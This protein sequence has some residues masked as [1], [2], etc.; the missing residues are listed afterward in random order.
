VI[1]LYKIVLFL[2]LSSVITFIFIL[3]GNY[4]TKQVADCIQRSVDEA[5]LFF[6]LTK[7]RCE[8]K[9]VLNNKELNSFPQLKNSLI[10]SVNL[11]DKSGFEIGTPKFGISLKKAFTFKFDDKVIKKC[12]DYTLEIKRCPKSLKKIIKKDSE[13]KRE[14]F[15]FN[16]LAFSKLARRVLIFRGFVFFVRVIGVKVLLEYSK[17]RRTVLNL[18]RESCVNC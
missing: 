8:L 16:Q 4:K 6:K 1:V 7:H 12:D 13:V 17:N 2:I 10:D 11:I 15:N 5:N 9:K 3:I 14:F 18:A